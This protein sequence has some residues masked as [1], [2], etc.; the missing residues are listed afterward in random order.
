MSVDPDTP[1]KCDFFNKVE[2]KRERDIDF[3]DLDIE[4]YLP[5]EGHDVKN[6]MFRDY[7]HSASGSM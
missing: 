3:K 6:R 7:L 4:Q 5:K 2:F 1:H